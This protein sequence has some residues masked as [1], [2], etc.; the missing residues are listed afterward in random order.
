MLTEE[1]KEEYKKLNN[2]DDLN[3]CFIDACSNGHLEI[4]KYLLT[5]PILKEYADVRACESYGF[6]LACEN[7]HLEIVKYLLTDP[8]LKEYADVHALN[9]YG[10]KWACRASCENNRLDVIKWLIFD[11]NIEKTKEISNF[12]KSNK[13]DDFVAQVKEMFASRDLKESLSNSLNSGENKSKI[14]L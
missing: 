13:D 12:L 5:D 14:K 8:S 11:Y 10:F 3:D 7:G 2:D 4:V 6:R 1:Q 9:D